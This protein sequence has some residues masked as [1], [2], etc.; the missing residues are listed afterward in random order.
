MVGRFKDITS[1]TARTH[2]GHPQITKVYGFILGKWDYSEQELDNLPD[3]VNNLRAAEQMIT[4][5]GATEE[6]LT[7]ITDPNIAQVRRKILEL[8]EILYDNK[9][10]AEPHNIL[11]NFYFGGHCQMI[12]N[13]LHI[14]L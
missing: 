11:I 12:K 6:T 4:L 9:K 10:L 5:L 13:E 14:L 2:N 8:E 1:D 7:I 3:V